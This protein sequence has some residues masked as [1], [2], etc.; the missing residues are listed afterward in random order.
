MLFNSYPFI[1]IFLPAALAGYFAANRLGTTAPVIWLAL[2]SLIFYSFSNWPFVALLLASI[3]F[4]YFIG[5]LLI[6]AS[7]RARPRFAVLTIGVSG[8]L[9]ALSVFKYAGFVVANVD[10]LFSTSFAVNIL[11]PVGISFYTFTQIAFLV[12]AYRGKVAHYAL[13][14]YALFVTYFPHLIAGPILHH[15]DMIPQFESAD[16]KRI[17]PRLILYGLIIFGI[18]LFKK[19]VLAD[20]IQPLVA[21]AFHQASPSFDQAW[22]GALAYTFQLYFDFSGYS[23]MA[24]GISLMFG[25]F[26]PLNFNSP[27]KAASIID[28]WRRWHMTL[29]Q[30]L[31]DYLYIP[32]GGNRH[33]SLL[34]YVNLMITMLLGGL[35][36]GAAWTFVIWGALHGLYLCINHAWS[37][38][39]PPIPDSLR[40][41]AGIASF[42]LTFLAVVVAWVFFRA[43]SLASATSVL[44]RMADPREIVFGRT[45]I[46]QSLMITIYAALAWFAPNTQEI[47]GYD[48]KNRSVGQNFGA[49]QVRPALLYGG[50]AAF[51][52]GVLGIQ[53]H[54][55]FIYFRF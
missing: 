48:H 54:S 3:A 15:R 24:I 52:L 10:A 40:R 18:G 19:T 26:L 31:R 13:P 51:A 17:N 27:Y 37:N 47:V 53:Q 34:R 21:A 11:L 25:I 1:F 29:S 38:Y 36:H 43:D 45:E 9:L 14:H 5:W 41:T 30:F 20:G 32:L 42:L 22:I 44:S 46:A 16:S 4:N 39:G 12:D 55:E 50:A 8:D 2:A 7:L 49:W 28:F 35:W 33:G 6:S 23:D